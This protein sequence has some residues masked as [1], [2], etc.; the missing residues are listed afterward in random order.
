MAIVVE[1]LEGEEMRVL[2][3]GLRDA[4]CLAAAFMVLFGIC[5]LPAA[6]QY[7]ASVQGTITD[8]Q[9]AVVPNAKITFTDKETNRVQ[10]AESNENGVYNIGGLPPSRYTLTVEKEGFKKKTLEDVGILSEQANAVNVIL[11]VGQV[12]E[13]VTV[14]GDAAPLLDTETAMLGGTVDSLE[15][16]SLPAYGRDVFQLLQ[17]A[18]GAFADGAQA[19]GG[20][21]NN[22]PSRNGPGGS[23]TNSGIFGVQNTPAISIGG[24]RQEVTNIQIDGVGSTDATWGGTTII[25]PNLDSVKEVKV[26]TNDYDAEDGRYSA[27][28]IKV[29]TQNGTNNFHG[30]AHWRADRAGFNAYQSYNGPQNSVVKNGTSLNDFGGSFGGP[31]IHNKL[32]FF[33]SYETIRS[34][35]SVNSTGW[36]ETSQFRTAAGNNPTSAAATILGYTGAAPITGKVLE[37]ASTGNDCASIGLIQG[38]NCNF[39]S[40]QGLDIGSPLTTPLGTSDPTFVSNTSPGVGNGLDGIA[41]IQYLAQTYNQPLTEQQYQGRLDFNATSKDLIAFSFFYVPNSQTLVNGT[42]RTM[43]IYHNNSQNYTGTLIWDHTFTSTLQNEFRANAGGWKENS[44]ETN[45]NSP[46]GLPILN[47]QNLSGTGIGTT[48]VNGF[49]IG[50]PLLFDQITYSAKDVLTKVY[51]SHTIKMGG[52]W[53][54]LLF[55]DAAPWNA[56]PTY[57]FNNMWDLLND[58]PVQEYATFNPQTGVPSDS[59]LDS[60]ETLLGFFVQ[61]SWKVKPTL[62]VTAGL[63]YEYFGPIS[64]KNGNLPVVLL[65]QGDNVMQDLRIRTGGNL[66]NAQK[67][68]FGPQLGFAW[69]PSRMLDKLVIRGGYGIGYSALQEANALDGRNNPPYLSSLLYFQ[70]NQIVYGANTFPSNVGSINGYAANPAAVINFS[71]TTNLP[72][73]GQ[74]YAPSNLVAYQQNWPT[75]RTDRYSLDLQYDLGHNWVASVGYQG[76]NSRH[77]T[78]LY[79]DSLYQYAQLYSEGKGALAFNPVVQSLTIYDDEGHGNFN[80][81]LASIRHRFGNSFQ[82]EAQYRYAKGLD[83]GSNNY[84]P[85]QVN[86]ACSCGGG[87]YEYTLNQDYGPSDFDVR[88]AFKLFGIWTP[89]I[90]HG[91]H[92]FWVKALD[93]WTISGIMNAHTGFPWNPVDPNLGFNGIYQGTGYAYG[94]GA[95]LRPGF[96][97]GAYNPGNYRTQQFPDG[98]LSIFPETNPDTGQACYVD[99]PPLSSITDG[100]AAPG[101]IPCA[102]AIGRNMYRGPGYFDVDASIGKAFHLP[103]MKFLGE[104]A[105]FMFT[106]NFYNLFNNTNLTNIDTNVTDSHFGMALNALGSRTIDFQLRFNF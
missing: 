76:T 95:P 1:S 25:T 83:T 106:A 81:L 104:G 41:D 2:S 55:E 65:G 73:P 4:V 102:P 57:N 92:S 18:P 29:I 16:Q 39:I 59:R 32:F 91:D 17:V 82:V 21:T 77:L 53:T 51:H 7:R 48:S 12:S 80:A 63:R 100:S 20:G 10:T 66:Y 79:N 54:R 36:F 15:V 31:I 88:H 14:N 90:F 46:W 34:N 40:G 70:G 19:A 101:P 61:D 6:A 8:E 37:G 78:R 11:Q 84:A 72:I 35:G 43:N 22:L 28:Q 23:S 62:T 33:A 98:A 60:R 86:G 93:G 64:A 68:N 94:G 42:A 47:Y 69:T 96:I 26:V 74:N 85:A 58:A 45:P 89:T 5:T 30:S 67:D 75:T 56:R 13:T 99:G 71:P 44:L 38:T 3:T 105:Q 52:D 87:S 27:G 9:G 50:T 103:P 49:G 97:R 24:G